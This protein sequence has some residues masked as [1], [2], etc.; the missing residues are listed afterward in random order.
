MHGS[1]EGHMW[2]CLEHARRGAV[3]VVFLWRFGGVLVTTCG[4]VVGACM[5]AACGNGGEG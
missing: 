5:G 2:L 1:M 4:G 3:L